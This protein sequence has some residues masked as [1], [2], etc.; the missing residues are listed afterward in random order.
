MTILLYEGIWRKSFRSR[1]MAQ[2]AQVHVVNQDDRDEHATISTSLS[3]LPPLAPNNVRLQTRLFS[4]T[5]NNIT[6]AR[7]GS[8]AHWWDAFPVPS[9][10]PTPYNDSTKYG[11]VPVWGYAEVISSHIECLKEGDV[12]YGFWPS[13]SLPID[14]Q[15]EPTKPAG[16][17]IDTTPSRQSMWSYYHRYILA[18]ETIDLTSPELAAQTV[19]KPLFD[20]A[21]ALN[22]YVLGQHAIHPSPRTANSPW[23]HADL[24]STAIISLSA[25]GKTALAL[26]DAVLNSRKPGSEPLGFLAIT[27]TPTLTLPTPITSPIKTKTLTYASALSTESASFLKSLPS[28][29]TKILI[30]D[31]GGRASSLPSLLSHLRSHTPYLELGVIGVGSSPDTEDVLAALASVPE[32]VQMN[33]SEVR[34]VVVEAIGAGEYFDGVREAW[35]GFCERGGCEGVEVGVGRGVEELGRGWERLCGGKVGSGGLVYVL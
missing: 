3:N 32:R 2:D 30:I 16:H 22:T 8:F 21:H 33:T 9:F 25:S 24:S 7:M 34:E 6:Y 10:L 1:K 27:S 31:F 17:F 29:L 14:L 28:T 4:M 26:T 20:C 35:E 19:F 11:I 23:P 18:P 12:F 13:S 5:A 15:L